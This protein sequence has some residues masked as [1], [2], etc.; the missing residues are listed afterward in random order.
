MPIHIETRQSGAGI[1]LD[2]SGALTFS[3]FHEAQNGFLASTEKLKQVKYV[4]LDLTFADSLNISYGDFEL[5]A[6]REKLLASSGPPGVLHATVSPKDLG[7][8]LARMYQVL[9]EQSGWET[10]V[11]RSRAEAEEWI[12]KRA[13]EKFGLDV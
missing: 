13:H 11:L 7:Y 10:L 3:E 8:G 2:C 9:S 6:E 12:R 1:I 4:I 5:L